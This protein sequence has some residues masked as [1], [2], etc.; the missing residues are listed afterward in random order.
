MAD[1]L[2][3]GVLT[4]CNLTNTAALGDM[5][6]YKL[7]PVI[8]QFFG[9]RQIGINRAYLA[10]GAD[11]QVDLLA[12][13]WDE[14]IRPKIGQYAVITKYRYQENQ[15]GD[16]YRITLVQPTVNEDGLRVFDLQLERLV[17][18]YEATEP[19]A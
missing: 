5:A 19:D 14:G 7:V 3:A 18:Y 6:S 10:K 2:D 11:E 1:L 15:D 13:I 12:R 16:Q 4:L 8:S 17:D 9:E